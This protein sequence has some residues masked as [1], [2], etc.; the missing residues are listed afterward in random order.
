[1][2]IVEHLNHLR[3]HHVNK[4]AVKRVLE[5]VVICLLTGTTCV[6]LPAA[7]ACK[8]ELRKIVLEDSAGCLNDAD[9]F[10]ISQGNTYIYIY[11]E[12]SGERNEM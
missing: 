8:Q 11:R 2:I 6:L 3:V 9:R 4:S 1:M 12:E 7:F 5:V 10:Q